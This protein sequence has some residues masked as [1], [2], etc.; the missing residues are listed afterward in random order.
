MPSSALLAPLF[1]SPCLDANEGIDLRATESSG[2][3]TLHSCQTNQIWK[4]EPL[5]LL[6]MKGYWKSVRANLLRVVD[7]TFCS[8]PIDSANCR[9][10]DRL[11][12][13]TSAA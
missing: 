12:F 13:G 8:I 2:C 10:L 9:Y 6:V 3:L 11:T 4:G 7:E 1:S 5:E